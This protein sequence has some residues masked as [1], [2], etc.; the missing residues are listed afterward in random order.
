MPA[1]SQFSYKNLGDW[2][3][4]IVKSQDESLS[5]ST[6]LQDDNEIQFPAVANAS[7]S[8][9]M[10]L[11]YTG[12]GTNDFKHAF[13]LTSG[14]FTR[15]WRFH[16]GLGPTTAI[17]QTALVADMT[18]AI[19]NAAVSEAAIVHVIGH[20]VTDTSTTVKLQWAQ[21]T[22]DAGAIVVKA[23]SLLRYRRIAL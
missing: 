1:E 21:Q 3:L 7:Y 13:A 15:S 12:N 16:M 23:G 6:T 5:A 11:A 10:I 17:A 22:S 9:E 4:E 2:G 14:T 20:F 19:N 8:F 18:T